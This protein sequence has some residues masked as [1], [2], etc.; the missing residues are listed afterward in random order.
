MELEALLKQEIMENPL[1]EIDEDTPE[2]PIEKSTE[3]E[4]KIDENVETDSELSEGI[5]ET[6]E[7]SEILDQW[8]EYHSESVSRVQSV[9][10]EE[11]PQFENFIQSE[12]NLKLSFMNE[13]DRLNLTENEYN[14]IYDLIDSANAHGFLPDDFDIYSVAAEHN[15]TSSRAD[16]LHIV[17]LTTVPRG[18]TARN[19][20]ECLYHQLEEHEQKKLVGKII[21]NDFNELLHRKYLQIANKYDLDEE[22]ILRARDRIGKLDPKP[23]LR[24]Y[25]AKPAY[26]VPDIFLVRVGDDFEIIINDF[27]IPRITFSRK[28]Q[29]I[30][31]DVSSDK[32]AIS[33]VRGK[34]NSAKFLIK[35]IFM[36]HRTLERVMRS[37]LHHQRAYFYD[38][39][40]VL[41]PLTYSVI[42]DDLGVNESTI[43]RV[44][45]SKYADT[46]L[47]VFCLKE[48]FCTNAGK[49]RSYESVS[50]HSVIQQVK[51]MIDNEDKNAPISDQ[52][53]VD[54]LRERGISV[55]RRVIAKYRDEMMIPNSRHRR[56]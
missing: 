14:F 19:I 25:N 21:L 42:A 36:R 51:V 41:N 24:I 3:S 34:I 49:D 39:S 5:V 52:D 4:S 11:E 30:L 2:E 55:S 47:G 7:L 18:I 33:Y 15:I 46:H 12:E 13:F 54:I 17:I 53:I 27:S 56:N 37:I 44:V 28:Y 29:N 8:N 32:E 40:G 45:K 16:E 20:K 38:C 10:N 43:S 50:K 6:K 22:D 26:I 31:S 35:T 1:L 48:F 23:G 9:S